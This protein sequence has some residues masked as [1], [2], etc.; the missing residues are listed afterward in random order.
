[1]ATPI[2]LDF[3]SRQMAPLFDE[4]QVIQVDT[5]GQSLFGNPANG[6]QTIFSPDQNA[7]DFEVVR[8]N[9]RTASMVPRGSNGRFVGSA[10]ATQPHADLQVG[11]ETYFSRKYPLIEESSNVTADQLLNRIPGEGAF[12]GRARA[13]RFR[14]QMQRAYL[15]N[16]RRIIRLDEYLAWQ[17]LLTGKQPQMLGNATDVY[18]F[19]RNTSNITTLGT[20]WATGTPLTDIDTGCDQ[21]LATGKIMPDFMIMGGTAMA[22][23][24]ANSQ[25]TTV[26]GN[27]L[28][29]D[30]VRVG[31][32]FAADGR[33]SRLIAAGAIPYGQLRTPKG[34][35]LTI[36]TYPKGYTNAAGSYTKYLADTV[37]LIGCSQA[38]ADRY[39]GP[40]ERLPMAAQDVQLFMERMGFNPMQP[41]MPQNVLASDGVIVPQTFFTDLY[42][43]ADKKKS[44]IRVQHAPIFATTQTDAW[45]TIN[46]C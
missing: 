35:T 17:S 27:K 6:S 36:F 10:G 11:Q 1:M 38:R 9:E 21:I 34:Y 30:L 18:D 31:I 19:R 25:I 15:E 32:D 16:M 4:K 13:D 7:V 24:L 26:Y 2:L 8:G 46:N 28:F 29:Y 40:P 37:T 3:F 44:T 45:Y 20:T 22:R 43:S 33:F 5:V 12:E 14:T 41:S 39:F 42:D 23:F